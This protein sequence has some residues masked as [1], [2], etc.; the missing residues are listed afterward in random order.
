MKK[1]L[2]LLIILSLSLL[3]DNV[4]A[5]EEESLVKQTMKPTAFIS[6]CQQNCEEDARQ[7]DMRYWGCYYRNLYGTPCKYGTPYKGLY[8]KELAIKECASLREM[9]EIIRKFCPKKCILE[10]AQEK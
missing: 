5:M 6:K 4:L 1:L 10:E 3:T 9:A 2:G 7:F 8:E